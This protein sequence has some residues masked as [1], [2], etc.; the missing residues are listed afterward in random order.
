MRGRVQRSFANVRGGRGL[1]ENRVD[2]A[3]GAW[4]CDVDDDDQLRC[5][6]L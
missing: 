1:C 5:Y 6:R 2:L 4:R 3:L